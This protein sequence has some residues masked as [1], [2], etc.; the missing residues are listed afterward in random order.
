MEKIPRVP[1]ENQITTLS[2]VEIAIKFSPCM[3]SG[4]LKCLAKRTST[5]FHSIVRHSTSHLHLAD[6]MLFFQRPSPRSFLLLQ[7]SV[8]VNFLH[9][10]GTGCFW[11][12]QKSFKLE[13]PPGQ[14]VIKPAC[15]CKF[16]D[17]C[18][19]RYVLLA[20]LRL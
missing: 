18:E 2:V 12:N 15:W 11:K 8:T 9:R 1:V 10:Y 20:I 14:W 16:S 13:Y 5:C 7:Y 6:F 19:R 4:F 3:L 17:A